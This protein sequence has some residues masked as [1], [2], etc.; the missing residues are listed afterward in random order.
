MKLECQETYGKTHIRAD[1][2]LDKILGK[3][4]QRFFSSI[5][6]NI[7]KHDKPHLQKLKLVNYVFMNVFLNIT[8]I[9]QR[10]VTSTN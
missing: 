9:F 1:K 7:L 8:A 10:K 6:C 3:Q 4:S 5:F 2:E